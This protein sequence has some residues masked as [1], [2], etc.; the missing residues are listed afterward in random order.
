MFRPALLHPADLPEW[1][2]LDKRTKI[3]PF[4][5]QDSNNFLE[6]RHYYSYFMG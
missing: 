4:F 1:N 5:G 2:A 6:K 3:V